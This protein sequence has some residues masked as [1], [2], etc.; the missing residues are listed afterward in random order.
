MSDNHTHHGKQVF[1]ESGMIA[2]SFGMF[3]VYE[4]EN[5]L[6]LTLKDQ[7]SGH[8]GEFPIDVEDEKSLAKQLHEEVR[9][10]GFFK[11]IAKKLGVVRN[12]NAIKILI[13]DVVIED[14]DTKAARIAKEAAEKAA[15]EEAERL[16]REEQERLAREEEERKAKA[17]EAKLEAERRA[18][19]EAEEE[20]RLLEALPEEERQ[21]IIAERLGLGTSLI[22]GVQAPE[23]HIFKA[24]VHPQLER[25]EIKPQTRRLRTHLPK[26]F[27]EIEEQERVREEE[28]RQPKEQVDQDFDD[29]LELL[30]DYRKE[31]KQKQATQA[32]V[33]QLAAPSK[34]KD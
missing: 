22:D 4:I 25:P 33:A 10:K 26:S 9:S 15:K 27:A 3:K 31:M 2:G 11:A 7:V 13:K 19:E 8:T 24:D 14:P 30:V 21:R 23:S 5:G 32:L 28:S 18:K 1:L 34:P 6:L 20:A 17:L 16:A 29:P 12:E